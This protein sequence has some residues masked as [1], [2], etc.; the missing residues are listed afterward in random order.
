MLDAFTTA[1]TTKIALGDGAFAPVTGD[2]DRLVAADF[3]GDGLTDLAVVSGTAIQ[4]LRSLP[5]NP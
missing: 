2:I 5:A 3:N 4:L 1:A